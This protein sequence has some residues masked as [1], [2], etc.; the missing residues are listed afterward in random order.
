MTIQ[1]DINHVL[2][3]CGVSI[4]ELGLR[5]GWISGF[6]RVIACL[7]P[8]KLGCGVANSIKASLIDVVAK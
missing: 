3:F 2:Q 6:L 1:L 5:I 7:C 8:K 4:A